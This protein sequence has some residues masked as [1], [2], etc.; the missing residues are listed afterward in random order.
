M[1]D[2]VGCVRHP[3]RPHRAGRRA[4]EGQQL[5]RAAPDGLVREARRLA[6]RRPAPPGRGDRLG[7]PRFIVTPDRQ[8]GGLPSPLRFVDGPLFPAVSGSTT[9]TTPSFRLRS[10]VPVGHQVRVC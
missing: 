10:A 1:Q 3:F 7:W 6:Y 5:G 2:G 9:R 8:A 4:E